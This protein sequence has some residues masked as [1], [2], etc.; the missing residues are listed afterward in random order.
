[1]TAVIDENASHPQSLGQ[2]G[3]PDVETHPVDVLQLE[4]H[5]IIRD[6]A[7]AAALGSSQVPVVRAASRPTNRY[8]R[9]IHQ[10]GPSITV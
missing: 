6:I 1:M 2:A 5:M 3:N 10:T 8:R 7:D 4:R 9:L